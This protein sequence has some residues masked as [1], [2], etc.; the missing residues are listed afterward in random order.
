MA[1]KDGVFG[2]SSCWGG[3]FTSSSN[4]PCGLN[5]SISSLEKSSLG[6]PDGVGDGSTFFTG[7]STGVGVGVAAGA[8]GGLYSTS[9]PP[10]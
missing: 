7:G 10:P 9:G 1:A 3:F 5:G 6:L 2:G 8:W 4:S